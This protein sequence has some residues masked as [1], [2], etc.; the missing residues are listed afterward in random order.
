ML[1]C[2][3]CCRGVTLVELVIGLAIVGF[4]LIAGLPS[5]AGWL[6][7][8]QI[9]TAAEAIQNGLQLARMEA[10]RQNTLIQFVL[11]TGSAWTVGCVATTGAC[12]AVIQSRPAEGS[13]NVVVTPSG[14]QTSIIFNG[15]GRLA[16]VAPAATPL[17]VD[18]DIANPTGGSC[19]TSGGPMRCLRVSVSTGGQIRMCDPALASTDPR[20]C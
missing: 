20:G 4:L 16:P 5:F 18:L 11:G 10:V 8:A 12:P 7:K 1:A 2:R 17:A 6:Q 15:M 3:A 14:G 13:S 19:A 9:R